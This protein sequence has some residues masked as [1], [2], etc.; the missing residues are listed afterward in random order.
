[1]NN[2]RYNHDDGMNLMIEKVY[3]LNWIKQKCVLAYTHWFPWWT[4]KCSK[5]SLLC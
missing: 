2:W 3:G 1:M 5:L 4:Y